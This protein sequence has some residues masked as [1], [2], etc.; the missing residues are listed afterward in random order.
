MSTI[1]RL[2]GRSPFGLLQRHMQQVAKC[3]AKMGE[4]LQALEQQKWDQMEALAEQASHLEHEADQIKDDIR[5]KLLR[6]FFMAVNRQQ[7]LQILAIQDELADAAENVAVLLTIR[8]LKTPAGMTEDFRKFRELNIAAFELARGVIADLDEL[9]E[10]GF[11]G[12][13]AEKIRS[14]VRDVAYTEHQADVVQRRLLK[15]VF[16]DEE[17]LSAADMNMWMQLIKEL[18]QLSNLSENLA[19]GVQMTLDMK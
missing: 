18:A 9:V 1:G 5:N 10:T 16:S 17:E 13:E 6:R 12:A 3:I 15:R 8:Q 7:I 19:D 4:S 14:L 11:G 2:L